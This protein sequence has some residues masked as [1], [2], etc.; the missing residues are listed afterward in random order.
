MPDHASADR[1]E[2]GVLIVDLKGFTPFV[3]TSEPEHT[4]AT[5]G[6]YHSAVT[7]V[8]DRHHGMVQDMVGDAVCVIF[9]ASPAAPEPDLRTVRA[10]LDLQAA[11]VAL[12][13]AW[14]RRGDKLG[15]GIGVTYGFATLGSV[16][17]AERA[18]YRAI[19][20]TVLVASRLASAATGG[21]ILATERLANA[22]ASVASG[23]LLADVE[24]RGLQ[25]PP[26]V[27]ELVAL[28]P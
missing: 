23:T 3:E 16:H 9:H 28:G 27:F 25:R 14:T 6:E 26:R 5:L 2:V 15:F 4:F 7:P 22:A 12:V 18:E 11:L 10:A 17:V 20:S 13:R 1:R 19:G 8:V 24:L 21:R